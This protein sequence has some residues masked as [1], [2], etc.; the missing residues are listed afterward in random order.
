MSVINGDLKV[1][2]FDISDIMHC[3][4]LSNAD[5]STRLKVRLRPQWKCTMHMPG[6]RAIRDD[7]S[8]NRYYVSNSNRHRRR[9]TLTK[10]T[11]ARGA[12]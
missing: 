7:S 3:W 8:V 12:R 10:T 2:L 6:F 11:R 5:V 4:E 1:I 9:T